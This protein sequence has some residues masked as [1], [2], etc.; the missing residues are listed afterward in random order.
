ML[1]SQIQNLILKNKTNQ[2][3]GQQNLIL[4]SGDGNANDNRTSFP[5]IVTIALDYGWTVDIWSWKLSFS[6]KFLDLQRKYPYKI[7][8][9]YLDTYR[10]KITFTQKQKRQHFNYMKSSILLFLGLFIFLAIL[11]YYFKIL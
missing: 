6:Y 2:G 4:I 3:N 10:S 11:I 7:K 9:N 8:I 5:D 1:H